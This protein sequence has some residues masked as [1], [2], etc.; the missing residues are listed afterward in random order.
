MIFDP[1]RLFKRPLSESIELAVASLI[2]NRSSAAWPFSQGFLPKIGY[3]IPQLKAN[4]TLVIATQQ[5]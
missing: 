4:G 1:A 3:F 5:L 2:D